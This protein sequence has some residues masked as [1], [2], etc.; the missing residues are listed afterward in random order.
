MQQIAASWL[1]LELTHSPVAV[2][3][4]ALAQLLPVTAL[5]LFVGTI[6]DRFEVRRVAIATETTQLI[7]SAVLALLTLGGWIA[8]WEIY[9]LA[10]VQGLA[11]S[12]GGPA[13][14]ALVFQMVGRAT[15]R[16]PSR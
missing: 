9:A 1:V 12:V 7:I 4:L 10:V 6:I 3:A 8:V 16:T 2:G 14:H 13:R 11:Q 5:G 15:S